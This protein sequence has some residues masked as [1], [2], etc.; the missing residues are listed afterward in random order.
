ML[1][2]LNGKQN[3]FCIFTTAQRIINLLSQ[4]TENILYWQSSA[5]PRINV[6]RKYF[7]NCDRFLIEIIE[8]IFT[9]FYC[10]SCSFSLRCNL[11]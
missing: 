11:Q 7:F 1:L 9:V 6:K 8:S 3:G 10:Q 5:K 4:K 2:L